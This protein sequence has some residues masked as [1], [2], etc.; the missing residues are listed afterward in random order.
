MFGGVWIFALSGVGA[1]EM[2]FPSVWAGDVLDVAFVF[3]CVFSCFWMSSGCFG[4]VVH[5]KYSFPVFQ[6]V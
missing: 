2:S 1:A 3:K 5:L 4:F 6:C